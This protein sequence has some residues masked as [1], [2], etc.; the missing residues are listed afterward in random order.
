MKYKN[1]PKD[2]SE[3]KNLFHEYFHTDFGRFYDG[4]MSVILNHLSIDIIKFDNYLQS[5]FGDYI[6][7]NKSMEDII[8]EK[9]GE[10]ANEFINN[11]I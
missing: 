11:L 10:K 4:L 3:V 2:R 1:N 6:S 9:Y 5:K 7:E 8:I